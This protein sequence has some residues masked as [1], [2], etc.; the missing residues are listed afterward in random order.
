MEPTGKGDCLWSSDV[1][2]PTN[3]VCVCVCEGG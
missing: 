1:A 2:D 3:P